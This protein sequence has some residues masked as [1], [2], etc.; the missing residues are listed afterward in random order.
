MVIWRREVC[1]RGA[2]N[3]ER[4]TRKSRD[5]HINIYISLLLVNRCD[6]LQHDIFSSECALILLFSLEIRSSI[7]FDIFFFFFVLKKR[8]NIL[9]SSG[10]HAV[11]SALV[12][13]N[14]AIHITSSFELLASI[15]NLYI[16]HHVSEC[17]FLINIINN[18]KE[19]QKKEKLTQNLQKSCA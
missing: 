11:D 19:F 14:S 1:A 3:R 4:S 17:H 2:V 8:T 5:V 7:E 12:R 13:I 16:L 18:N 6:R 15:L 10:V 9:T